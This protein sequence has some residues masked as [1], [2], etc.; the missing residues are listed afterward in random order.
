[1]LLELILVSFWDRF[2]TILGPFWVP[3]SALEASWD[4]L[5]R[6]LGSILEALGASWEH[7]GT[8][9]GHVG[10]RGGILAQFCVHFGCLGSILGAPWDHLGRI[11]GAFSE[12]LAYLAASWE[13]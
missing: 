9:L 5:W 8:I 3:K 6:H 4:Q 11:L 13:V 10:H 7:L 1:M 2:E 12:Y